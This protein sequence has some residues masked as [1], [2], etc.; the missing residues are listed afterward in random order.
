MLII[1]IIM[2]SVSKI[3]RKVFLQM[4]MAG[5]EEQLRE[6]LECKICFEDKEKQK[7]LPCQHTI[8]VDC[9]KRLEVKQ[10][11]YKCPLCN[12]VSVRY[13]LSFTAGLF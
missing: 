10:S 8:C 11:K 3:S 6:M 2:L 1:I 13:K 9:L 4:A 7:L 12:R 5:L